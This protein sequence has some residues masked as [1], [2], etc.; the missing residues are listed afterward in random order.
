MNEQVRSDEAA[1]ALAE[2]RGRQEQIIEAVL[3]PGWFWWTL[4]VLIVGLAAVAESGNA[5][6]VGVGVPVFV[7]G[8][9]TMSVRLAFG[10]ERHVRVRRELLGDRG[11]LAIVGFTL[12]VVGADLG[13]AFA[14]QF[15]GV[16]YPATVACLAAAVALIAGGPALMRVLRRLMLDNRDGSAG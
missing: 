10:A 7:V 4:G 5:V 8:V 16:P 6:A 2:I 3:V 1:R 15:G 13:F 9:V 11:V 14:L 12:A